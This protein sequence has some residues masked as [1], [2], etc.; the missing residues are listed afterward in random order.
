MRLIGIDI[1]IENLAFC[2]IDYDELT[3]TNNINRDTWFVLDTTP[4]DYKQVCEYTNKK[5]CSKDAGWFYVDKETSLY[6]FYCAAHKK[7]VDPEKE[8]D[9]DKD[10]DK[11]KRK[12]TWKTLNKNYLNN[13]EVICSIFKKLDERLELWR[14]ADYIIIEKQPPTNPKMISIMNYIYSYFVIR[15]W[16]DVSTKDKKLRDLLLLDA[17]NKVNYCLDV[18]PKEDIEELQKKYNPTKNKYQYYKRISI[19]TVQKELANQKQKELL[20]YF[21]GYKKIDDLADSRNMV[22][23]WLQ[24]ELNKQDKADKKKVKQLER[25]QKELERAN[26]PKRT[27]KTN[28]K[29]IDTIDSINTIDTKASKE[30]NNTNSDV[31]ETISSV[32]ETISSVKETSSTNSKISKTKGTKTKKVKTIDT[33]VTSDTNDIDELVNAIVQRELGEKLY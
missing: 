2:T 10:K 9:K 5:K 15:L 7:L 24:K 1:A 3:N 28:V 17:K 21:N 14:S 31:K 12:Y 23:W 19:L 27:R 6:R 11:E 4:E 8:L 13:N 16:N 26:K 22:L 30:T 18:L 25:E 32:K 20:D 29:T 33:S